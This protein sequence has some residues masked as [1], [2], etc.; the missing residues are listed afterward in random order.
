MGFDLEKTRRTVWKVN[1]RISFFTMMTPL[2]NLGP[3]EVEEIIEQLQERDFDYLEVA[4][5]VFGG[6]GEEPSAA[7]VFDGKK[8]VYWDIFD[9]SQAKKITAVISKLAPPEATHEYTRGLTQR[10]W[11]KRLQAIYGVDPKELGIL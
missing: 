10:D 6:Q 8:D 5:Y 1:D 3:E 11:R 7:L 2:L 9:S 4:S